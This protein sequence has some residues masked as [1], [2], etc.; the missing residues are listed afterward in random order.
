MR[1]TPLKTEKFSYLQITYVATNTGS[2]LCTINYVN[3]QDCAG[4]KKKGKHKMSQIC[5]VNIT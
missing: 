1:D 3:A 2:C 5:Q 4:T